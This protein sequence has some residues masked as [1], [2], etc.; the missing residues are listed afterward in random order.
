ME[1]ID[2]DKDGFV[3]MAEYIGDMYRPDD[4]PELQGKE[5]EWVESEREMFKEHRD[6]DKD[7][8]LNKVSARKNIFFN[9]F[10]IYYFKNSKFSRQL[11]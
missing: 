6:K 2:K 1:D 4:Y 11:F 7:G 8:K 9:F 3:D 5:P 10:G